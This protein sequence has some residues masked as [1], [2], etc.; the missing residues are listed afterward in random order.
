[1]SEGASGEGQGEEKTLHGNRGADLS[2]T[3]AWRAGFTKE[4]AME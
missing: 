4:A 1:L 3:R 2:M